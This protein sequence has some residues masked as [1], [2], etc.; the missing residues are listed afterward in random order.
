[1]VASDEKRR[2]PVFCTA[3]TG[4]EVNSIALDAVAQPRAYGEAILFG[5]GGRLFVPISTVSS[6]DSGAV[7]SYDVSTGSFVNFEPPGTLGSGWFL[8]FR[9]TDPATLAYGGPAAASSSVT[10]AA[11]TAGSSGTS[12][13]S[14]VFGTSPVAVVT[15]SV[16]STSATVPTSGA[17]SVPMSGATSASTVQSATSIVPTGAIDAVFAAWGEDLGSDGLDGQP[18]TS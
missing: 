1:M 18:A 3:T 15:A 4:A 9:N 6:P 14:G 2:C 12:A 7:R 11:T 17:T 10:A 8:T 5:P 16:P 13:L